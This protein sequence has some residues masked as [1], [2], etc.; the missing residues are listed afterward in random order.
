MFDITKGRRTVTVSPRVGVPREAR[1]VRC[2]IAL[3]RAVWEDVDVAAA[4]HGVSRSQVIAGVLMSAGFDG[5][6]V[7]AMVARIEARSAR[8]NDEREIARSVVG[9]GFEVTPGELDEALKIAGVAD[10]GSD[11]RCSERR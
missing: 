4:L 2:S 11:G 8:R 7:A 5:P 3:P 10:T 1:R 6:G 9:D